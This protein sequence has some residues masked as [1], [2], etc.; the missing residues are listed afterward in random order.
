M[1]RGWLANPE[2]RKRRDQSNTFTDKDCEMLLAKVDGI[3]HYISDIFGSDL[4]ILM[5][6]R[7]KAI[8]CLLWT[9]F[10]R[11][12]AI[13]KLKREDVIITDTELI[14]T[15][16]VQKKHKRYRMCS[17]C[18]VKNGYVNK[19]CRNCA[20]DLSGVEVSVT[21]NESIF[22]KRKTLTNKFTQPILKWVKIF[23]QLTGT[24]P[25]L[26]EPS[27]NSHEL[28]ETC[29]SSPKTRPNL[30]KLAN[31]RPKLTRTYA[32]LQELATSH[33]NYVIFPPLR[34]IFNSAYFDFE[35][36]KP[37]TV[38]NLNRILQRLDPTMTSSLFR[39]GGA[40]KWLILGYTPHDLKEI[41]DWATSSMPEKYA[42][43]KGISSA[44][45]EW[46]RD[47]R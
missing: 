41:G 43:K 25:N 34:V 39:Y 5:R 15:F 14:V 19:Y 8:I 21:K 4:D 12:K 35:P 23:D 10:K 45:R 18:G 46:S 31:S 24:S 38:S 26:Q 36:V 13:L 37:M 28:A 20:L 47:T 30:H 17:N 16:H 7:D 27:P 44:Q 29:I 1:Y 11:A 9:F 2:R 3:E 32:N 42:E 33:P 6:T 22:T 40:E